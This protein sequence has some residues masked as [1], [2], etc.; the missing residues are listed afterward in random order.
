MPRRHA[1]SV[2][3]NPATAREVEAERRMTYAEERVQEIIENEWLGLGDTTLIPTD[4]ILA[5]RSVEHIENPA[6]HLLGVARRPEYFSFTCRH[7]MN[8]TI[9]PMQACWLWE[10]WHRPFPMLIGSRGASKSFSLALYFMLRALLCQGVK[11]IV[12]GAAFRQA[13]VVFDYCE[14]IWQSSPILR[15]AVGSGNG[16]G[17][18]HGMDSCSLRLGDSLILAL[19]LGD[20]CLNGNTFILHDDHFGTISENA[21]PTQIKNTP[22][23]KVWGDG[24]FRA[25]DE[26]YNNGVRPTKVVRT[27]CG[28]QF[29]GTHNHR[30]KVVREGVVQWVRA[31][32]MEVGDRI[33]IDRAPRWHNGH[34]GLTP[35][36][37]WAVGC[38]IG[39]GSYY[40]PYHL[41]MTTRE[42]DYFLP[43]LKAGTGLDFVGY[44]EFG[45]WYACGKEAVTAWHRRTQI[46]YD[47]CSSKTIPVG[48]LAA[49]KEVVA[50]C[51]QGLFD[52][53]GTVQCSAAKG[54]MG[55]TVSYSTSSP[56]LMRQIHF[57]LLHFGI[58]SNRTHRQRDI[59]W[60]ETHEL[61][62]TGNDARLFQELIGF[63]RPHKRDLLAYGLS[64][65]CRNV[66]TTDTV[67]GVHEDMKRMSAANRIRRGFA[68]ADSTAVGAGR[69]NTV[70]TITHSMAQRFLRVYGQ[71]PD[72]AIE[73]IR[74]L[75]NP[76]IFY[77]EIA[78]IEDGECETFDIHVPDGHEYTANGFFS[79]N[80][81]IRGQRASITCAE[82]FSSI[83]LEIF[84][85]VV[86]GFSAVSLSPVEKMKSVA[87][88]TAMRRLGL[89]HQEEL[90]T[91]PGLN[92]N[93]TIISGTAYYRFNHFYDYWRRYKDIIES[94][95]DTK[96]LEEIF[97]GDVP[98]NFDYKDFCIIRVP[99]ELLPPGF[100]DE[101]TIGKAKATLHK[102]QW[103]MEFGAAWPTDSDGFFRRTLIE[104]CVV[105][106]PDNP[107]ELPSCG[108]VRFSA[109]LRGDRDHFYV[110]GVDPASE[111]DN[112]AIVILEVH[113]DH[114][115]IVFCWTTTRRR[116]RARLAK[117]LV[118]DENFYTYAARKIRDLCQAF[119]CV[120]VAM[121]KMG[122]GISVEE[123]LRDSANL[124]EG[125]IPIL[126]T[127]VEGD[128]KDTDRMPG[129]HILELVKFANADYVS[130]ANHGMRLDFE[131]KTLL[132]PE[133]DSASVGIAYEEDRARGRVQ[134][135]EDGVEERLF[136]TLEDCILDIEELKEE[137]ASIVHTQTGSTKRD[138]WD[139]PEGRNNLGQKT[140]SRKD[141]YSA[142]LMANMA[143]RTIA[144]TPAR[145]QYHMT[146][147]FAHD[148]DSWLTPPA[149]SRHQNPS[150]YDESG[151]GYSVVR[152]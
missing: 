141:R 101:K 130:G 9:S 107:I 33:L 81:K 89:P 128:E 71:L 111:S 48:V 90:P 92:A 38:L 131:S 73:K 115:R 103:L 112:F 65:K 51:L 132:F 97:K 36:E 102:S 63:G 114:R 98:P 37:G 10:L 124:E 129:E 84:E 95:G 42:P 59:K 43:R 64:K 69:L 66:S 142:L 8:R 77:D 31:D 2:D 17:P 22:A 87:R 61:L 30:M 106:R 145:P 1:R 21:G 34:I 110:M 100:M 134:T 139:T 104:T 76:D 20:G 72:P 15:D 136:D 133:F 86:Q 123:A 120:H 11:I 14:A 46:G 47:K 53:D 121:D 93:Q 32:E 16:N 24:R 55:V 85:N 49:R 26:C 70:K 137:L 140:R 150:W 82:E 148:P 116:H 3:P 117:S 12:V 80:S 75:A 62:I 109:A 78:S 74:A 147:G 58:V 39:D 105:G 83:N 4:N 54:G 127:I 146:G 126:P 113:P 41:K 27:Q 151:E 52:T 7:F 19:P 23:A 35:E 6:L 149:K 67:P 108:P 96:K 138:H 5:P 60:E 135:N 119:P 68:N 44:K 28:Y 40:S 50:S 57:L 125:E 122:G 144:L 152:R 25:T 94:R 99:V 79:H 45:K 13:K 29:E 118:Q 143:A 88:M 18:R 91:V 56:E